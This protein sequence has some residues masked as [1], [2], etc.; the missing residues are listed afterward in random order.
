[1]PDKFELKK[2]A[3]MLL[4]ELSIPTGDNG[5]SRDIS[6]IAEFGRR[7]QN[8]ALD[9]AAGIA[10]VYENVETGSI[11]DKILSLKHKERQ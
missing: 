1:M 4:A 6:L 5:F 11:S 10:A 2:E 3:E 7:C 8:S 9:Q